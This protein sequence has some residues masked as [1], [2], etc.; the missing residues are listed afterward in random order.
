MTTMSPL[1]CLMPGECHLP[2]KL[3]LGHQAL[4]ELR[5]GEYSLHAGIGTQRYLRGVLDFDPIE[6][7]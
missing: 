2:C 6:I 4:L 5:P 7:A 1:I 3:G